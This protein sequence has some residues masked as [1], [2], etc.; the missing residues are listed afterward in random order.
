MWWVRTD[1][2]GVFCAIFTVLLMF[3]AAFVQTY[4]VIG[5]WKGYFSIHLTLYLL[6]VVIS[7]ICHTKCQFSNPGTVPRT[8]DE[9]GV[10]Y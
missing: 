3:F 8:I 2:C 4:Y 5:P 6:L 7:A 10:L 1:C 9:V